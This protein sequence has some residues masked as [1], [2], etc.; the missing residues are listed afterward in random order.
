MINKTQH[1]SFG[2]AYKKDLTVT[3]DKALNKAFK[4]ADSAISAGTQDTHAFFHKSGLLSDRL[5]C[6][7]FPVSKRP[8]VNKLFNIIPEAFFQQKSAWSKTG[9]ASISTSRPPSAE[10]LN[11]LLEASK[12]DLHKKH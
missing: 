4:A 12:K 7:T 8:W 5:T 11:N 3:T 10:E 2:M 9:T 6:V 1:N